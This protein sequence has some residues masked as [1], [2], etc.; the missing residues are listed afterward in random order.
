MDA[1]IE[2]GYT[3][4]TIRVVF[5]LSGLALLVDRFAPLGAVLLFPISLNILLEERLSG[6]V[7]HDAV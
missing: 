1:I 2:S 6:P 5:V 3:F 7:D 4:P